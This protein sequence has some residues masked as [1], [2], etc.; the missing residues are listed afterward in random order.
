MQRLIDFGAAHGCTDELDVLFAGGI[1]DARSAA[2]VHA[3]A[4][5]LVAAGGAA[6]ILM[7]TAYLF[8]REAVSSGAIGP[9]FQ[10]ASSTSWA[11]NGRPASTSS[12]ATSRA[13]SGSRGS[14]DTGSTP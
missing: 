12:R 2:M 9:A 6:G 8:T 11:E 3:A 10:R 13:S 7:G 1:H 4:A 5:P 14:S